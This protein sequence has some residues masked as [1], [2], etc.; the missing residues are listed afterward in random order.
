MI[1]GDAE[2]GLTVFWADDG[3]DTGPILLQE[4][5][6]VNE[7]DTVDTLY[8]RF[9]YPMG[10]AAMARAVDLVALGN[11]PRVEQS[12]KGAT[13]DPMLNKIEL[14]RIDFRG[15]SG[16]ELHDFIR[17]MDSV[18]GA[19]CRLKLPGDGDDEFQ[20][21]RLFGSMLW[22]EKQQQQQP[23]DV[24][25]ILAR[26]EI[27]GVDKFAIIHDDGLLL[28]GN[29]GVFVN[30]KRVRINGKMRNAT[31][32]LNQQQN[33][34]VQITDYTQNEKTNLELI[35]NC[36]AAILNLDTIEG[37]T[38]FFANGAASMDVVRLIEETKTILKID[39]LENEDLFLNP[40]YDE[41]CA[42]VI[43]KT[44][45]N[46][47]KTAEIDYRGVE[48]EANGFQLKIPC[49][50]FI[51]GKFVDAR[52]GKTLPTINPH[53]ES[54]ICEVQCAG[55]ADVNAAVKAA[56]RAFETGEWSRISARERGQLLYKLADL[57]HANREQLATIESLDSGA[58][59]TLALK[60]HVG[61]SVETWRYFAGWCDKIHGT[62]IPITHARPNRN[63][64]FTRK[65]PLGV[66]GLITP[67]NYPLMML[68]WKMAACLAAGNTVVIKPAQ[69]CPLT[70]LK[71]AEFAAKAG[72]PPGVINV[73]PGTGTVAGNALATHPHVRKLGFTGSTEIGKTIMRTCAESNLKKCSLELGG[74]SPLIIF[75]DC[76]LEKAIRCGM[77]SV[78]F[79]KGENCIAAGRLF[80]EADVHD[81]FV[82]RVVRETR[83]MAIGD[84][85]VRGTAHGPQNHLAHL[86]K[87]VEFVGR[88][89]AEGARLECGGRRLDDRKGYYFEPTV[90]SQVEDHM[91]I[92]REES[93]GPIMIISKFDN[94]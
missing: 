23:P 65:E 82:R 55:A 10:V 80:V 50:L 49:Q 43:T 61:M 45:Q 88:G 44:R 67:W 41:F 71:F 66:C 79:N 58:V 56:K 40:T 64:T 81:E 9:L 93:F 4:R 18:P 13:Y 77:Q 53:D 3:L 62:T 92:A 12:E 30:V 54:V 46:G 83:R 36:W 69:V 34:N 87:L 17:G 38:D 90:F 74:K 57:L 2:A 35:R 32:L 24:D 6:H 22:K 60:T 85:L 47:E 21:V 25:E 73:I 31:D 5:C 28:E 39:H 1:C 15:K 48:F 27:E 70:A 20:E 89:V 14:Q 78:F 72:F 7:N 59:Y 76:D 29:D 16:R 94:G 37:E 63:L 84:P 42:A 91:F 19:L 11:A 8:K 51:D 26:I 52:D 33:I 75:A 86:N 68:S